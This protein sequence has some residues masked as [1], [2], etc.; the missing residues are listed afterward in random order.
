VALY[1]SRVFRLLG[2][3]N[4]NL[5]TVAE[6]L[7]CAVEQIAFSHPVAYVYN[8]L[9]YASRT[10]TT[11][12]QLYGIAPKRALFVGMN[13]GPYGMVQTGVPFG[14]VV[15]VRDWLGICGEVGKPAPEHPKK[16]VLGFSCRRREVSGRRLWS[17]AREHFETPERFFAEFF[18]WN[19][20]PLCFL[21]ESGRNLTPD[22]LKRI[23][24]Q[25]L[26]LVCDAAL[27]EIVNCL[28]PEFLIGVGAF[29]EGRL[30]KI[31]SE[32]KS[33]VL[34]IPHPS[35]AN[36]AANRNDWADKVSKILSEVGLLKK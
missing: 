16:P 14:D 28:R 23:E 9:V 8:P 4:V 30:R 18:V 21:E 33:R 32:D 36:P 13:P 27:V 10:H 5:V 31:L 26:F 12:L 1:R 6:K 11:Y 35:P 34:R 25:K 15:M 7:A 3:S 2:S 22:K 19:Y 24:C 17:W 29:A 20:C